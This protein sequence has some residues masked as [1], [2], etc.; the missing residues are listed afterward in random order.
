MYKKIIV[1]VI[2]LVQMF[3]NINL[4]CPETIKLGTTLDQSKGLKVVSQDFLQAYNYVFNKANEEKSIF[5]NLQT[6]DD[7]YNPQQSLA[8]LKLLHEK[9]NIDILFAPIG[10]ATL[11][12][13]LE[14][15][16]K[17][18][19]LTLFPDSGSSLFHK[20]Y[21]SNIINLWPAYFDV[22]Y[23]LISFS[24]DKYKNNMNKVAV[25]YQNDSFG[26]ELMRG[27]KQALKDNN[28][29]EKKVKFIFHKRNDLNSVANEM[30]NLD[31]KLFD[32][33]VFFTTTLAADEFIRTAKIENIRNKN[34]L[35]YSTLE[36]GKTKLKLKNEKINFV[37]VN[38]VPNYKTLD[39]PIAKQFRDSVSNSDLK[40]NL[41][42]F[43]GF[44]SAEL[45]VNSIKQIDVPITKKKIKQKLESLKNYDFGG[46]NLT[47]DSKKR[48]LLNNVWMDTGKV[49]WTKFDLNQINNKSE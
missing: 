11:E 28:F 31:T 5:I 26:K 43:K 41:P 27:A 35:G 49:G 24:L 34:I 40:L 17:N 21:A 9:M 47:F 23:A 3:V 6:L 10:T 45:L 19:I 48:C 16:K 39:L 18:N 42:N 7:M 38:E 1:K 25:F 22:A 44:L 14:Y 12:A 32:T 2:I 46:I 30:K 36:T 4:F 20:K 29:D 13:C 33:F 37:I 15:I 8:N